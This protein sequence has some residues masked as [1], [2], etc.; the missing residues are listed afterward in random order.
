MRARL[1]AVVVVIFCLG[2]GSGGP[3]QY[4]AVQGTLSYEDGSVIPAGGIRLKFV[5]QD[6]PAVTG[7]FPRPA[8]ANLNTQGHFDCVTSYKY[9]DGLVPGKHK[10]AILDAKDK[11]GKLLVPEEYTHITTTPL[12]VDTADAPLVIKIPK[13]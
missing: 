6:A 1:H 9:G 7:S 12:I 13:L 3:F 5:A 8:I 2:C 10:V 11:Q 4:G